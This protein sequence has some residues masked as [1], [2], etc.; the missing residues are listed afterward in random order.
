MKSHNV[1]LLSQTKQA[2]F[3]TLMMAGLTI[4]PLVTAQEAVATIQAVSEGRMMKGQLDGFSNEDKHKQI[5]KLKLNAK[6]QI[7]TKKDFVSRDDRI[8][9]YQ[10]GQLS[11]PDLSVVKPQ[12]MTAN[13]KVTIDRTQVQQAQQSVIGYRDFAIFE[14]YS[15]LFDDL[16]QDGFYQ[17]FSVTF[18]ADVYGYTLNEPANVY[19]E[20]YLSR[21][22]GPWEH[23]YTTDVFT[24]Y[25]QSED[26]DFEVLTTLSQGYQTDFYDVLIDLYEYGYPEVVATLSADESDG[27]YALALES[28]DRDVVYEQEIVEEVVIVGGGSLSWGALFLLIAGLFSRRATNGK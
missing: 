24:I 17:T 9:A 23:Y 27:L 22:G 2:A 6:Q 21:N 13:T 4:S 7:I 10:Q 18:D 26:D 3:A 12:T 19:A 5:E 20:M 1:S 15:R 8:A 14:A 16:D 25:G 11:P 28:H